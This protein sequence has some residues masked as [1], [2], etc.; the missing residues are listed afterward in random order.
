MTSNKLDHCLSLLQQNEGD[1]KLLLE[2]SQLYS[3]LEDLEQ[4]QAYLNKAKRIDRQS[5]LSIQGILNLKQGDTQKAKEH[6]LEA[7]E[8][9]KSAELKYNLAFTYYIDN[10]YEQAW[11]TLSDIRESEGFSDIPLLK[12]RILQQQNKSEQAIELLA[13]QIKLNPDDAEALSFLSLL[14]FDNNDEASAAEFCQRALALNSELYD[15]RLVDIMLRLLN[16]ET[17]IDEIERLIK[18]NP[19]DSRLWFALGSTYMGQGDFLL[20]EPHLARTL[21]I[22]PEFYDCHIALAW[23]QLLN[24]NIQEAHKTYQNAISIVDN[25]A[26]GWGGLAIIYA[27]NADLEQ[28]AQL[29]NKANSLN[30]DCFLT[31]IAQII[32]LTFKNPQESEPSVLNTLMNPELAASEKLAFIMSELC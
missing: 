13:A 5:C 8:Q 21:E 28:A 31:E 22:H 1:L 19:E 20:A 4:A 6:F 26:D 2:I 17:Q 29:I 27:L 32:Y 30:T 14:Y 7:L 16:Q 23:C 18:I 25:L 12:A 24:N 3:E 15:A 9:E 10:S 11:S